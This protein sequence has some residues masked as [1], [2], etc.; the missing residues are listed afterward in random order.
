VLGAQF[1]EDCGKCSKGMR[2]ERRRSGNGM[3]LPWAVVSS[4]PDAARGR[5]PPPTD[6]SLAKRLSVGKRTIELENGTCC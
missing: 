4:L 5:K 3:I 1:L 2:E 6:K